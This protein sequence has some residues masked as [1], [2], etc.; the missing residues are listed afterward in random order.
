MKKVL[1]IIISALLLASCKENIDQSFSA[2]GDNPMWSLSISKE[3]DVRFSMKGMD[4]EIVYNMGEEK[5]T[6]SLHK[7]QDGDILLEFN[8]L[9]RECHNY[10]KEKTETFQVIIR[11]N[12]EKFLGCGQFRD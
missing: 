9:E 2:S 3:K 10:T 8:I 4:K 12:G 5:Y 7:H 1:L 11:L 6:E